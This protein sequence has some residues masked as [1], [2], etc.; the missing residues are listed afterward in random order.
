[1]I[2]IKAQEKLFNLFFEHTY[3]SESLSVNKFEALFVKVTT[4]LLEKPAQLSKLHVFNYFY[5]F[6]LSNKCLLTFNDFILGKLLR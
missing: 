2:V 3:P 4:A 5:A 1:L 6:D